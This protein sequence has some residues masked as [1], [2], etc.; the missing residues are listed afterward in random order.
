MKAVS[1][2]NLCK[3][4]EK[5]DWVLCRVKGSHH[6]YKH[7]SYKDI[8]VIPVHKNEDLKPGMLKSIMKITDI[9]EDEL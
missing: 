2:K 6:I 1:D 9:K 4:I 5:R 7:E 3:I 8:L